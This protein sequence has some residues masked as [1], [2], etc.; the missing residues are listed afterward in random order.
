M[1]TA[2]DWPMDESCLP[3]LPDED[4]P[5]YG[6]AVLQRL[7]AEELAIAVLYALSGRQYGVC[8]VA[9]RPCVQRPVLS[10][11]QLTSYVLS[12]EGDRWMSWPCGCGSVCHHSGPRAV[13]LPGPV[14]EIVHVEI[15]GVI[16]DPATYTLED[17]VLYRR[18]GPWP[19]QDLGRPLG[20]A[21]TWQVAYR[22]GV[23]VPPSVSR[24]T[25][26][27]AA[28]FLMA[29]GGDAKCR[30]PRNITTVSRQGL[31]FQVYDPQAIY[32]AGKTNLPE[33]DLWLSAVNPHAVMAPPVVL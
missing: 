3:A 5:G 12:W 22:R 23:P 2:C 10:P 15:N 28:E 17:G 16:A 7:A 33:V 6:R 9:V 32:A 25:G 20:E 27:L 30:L 26:V 18:G 4:D 1:A 13:H 21:N 31:T 29:C 11:S 14:S 19:P 24:L 8:T